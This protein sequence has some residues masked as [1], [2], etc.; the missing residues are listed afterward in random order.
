[1][2]WYLDPARTTRWM[3]FEQVID[4]ATDK[5]VEA[6]QYLLALRSKSAAALWKCTAGAY[7][8]GKT[9]KKDQVTAQELV[10]ASLTAGASAESCG[11]SW[12]ALVQKAKSERLKIPSLAAVTSVAEE[13][14]NLNSL[15]KLL[16]ALVQRL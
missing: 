9:L 4:A 8:V 16:R 7:S 1:M 12:N 10:D 14:S 5:S 13:A 11:T 3:L 6:G 2:K 15:T